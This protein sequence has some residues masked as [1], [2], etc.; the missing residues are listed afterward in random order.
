MFFSKYKNALIDKSNALVGRDNPIIDK[1]SHDINGR[2][3]MYVPK[4]FCEIVLGMGWF[5][6][7]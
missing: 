6:G 7:S 4:G 5:L 1:L 3:L 2:D